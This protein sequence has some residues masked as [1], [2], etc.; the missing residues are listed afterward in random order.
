MNQEAPKQ[1]DV[2]LDL[3]AARRDVEYYRDRCHLL[4]RHLNGTIAALFAVLVAY[5]VFNVWGTL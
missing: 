4:Q 3:L 1:R 2:Y 5:A